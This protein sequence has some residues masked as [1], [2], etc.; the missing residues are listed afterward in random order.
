MIQLHLTALYP[1]EASVSFFYLHAI[2]KRGGSEQA[3]ALT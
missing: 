2:L 1:T 3:W